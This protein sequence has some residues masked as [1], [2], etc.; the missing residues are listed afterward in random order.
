MRFQF[1]VFRRYGAIC[2]VCGLDV[3]K[4]LEAAH[5][6]PDAENGTDDPRNGLVLCRNHHRAYDCGLFEIE[7]ETLV[8]HYT[9]EHVSAT[10][11]AISRTN[12]QHLSRKPHT[13]ALQWRWD[14]AKL[15]LKK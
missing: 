11:L 2:A 10:S 6:V 1:D 8:L 4:V 13:D 12:L 14:R 15:G 7:P 9:L 5:I 3:S